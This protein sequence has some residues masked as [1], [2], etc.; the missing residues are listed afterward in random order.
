MEKIHQLDGL[1]GWMSLWVWFAHGLSLASLDLHKNEGIGRLLV[2]GAGPVGVFILLSGFVCALML[3]R[4]DGTGYTGWLTR[5]FFR[6]FPVYLL[7][8][9]LSVWALDMSISALADNPW[10]GPRSQDRID[11]LLASR[12]NFWKH[13]LLHIPLLHGLVPDR[14]LPHTSLA[15]MGQA[16]SLSLEWQFYLVAPFLIGWILRRRPSAV[17][18]VLTVAALMGL[19]RLTPQDSFLGSHLYLFAVGSYTFAQMKAWQAGTLT[20]RAWLISMALDTAL[21]LTLSGGTKAISLVLWFATVLA[22]QH[23]GG[24]NPVY[25]GLNA[26]WSNPLSRFL[27]RVSYSVYC[28]HMLVLFSCSSLLIH[29]VGVQVQWQYAVALLVIALPLTLLAAWVVAI[30]LEEPMIA[31]GRRRVSARRAPPQVAMGRS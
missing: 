2:N 27:G 30:K 24:D 12:E 28:L 26:F 15:F 9:A 7:A 19:A 29:V 3:S 31:Y 11:Y 5:R 21:V 18:H 22:M 20:T 16:W 17:E 14:L 25:R 4:D 10:P 23:V 1:R 8:L 6:L 13:L